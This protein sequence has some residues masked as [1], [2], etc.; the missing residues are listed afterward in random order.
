VK[1]NEEMFKTCFMAARLGQ[2]SRTLDAAASVDP[3][4]IGQTLSETKN[5]AETY[6]KHV[7]GISVESTEKS[8]KKKITPDQWEVLNV[9]ND[10][11]DLLTH[12]QRTA[13]L[14]DRLKAGSDQMITTKQAEI[15][16]SILK[17]IEPSS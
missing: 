16:S 10:M 13:F 1:L 4:L 2:Q 7:K 15:I 8:K 3:S 5:A 14:P 11:P 17:Q 9:A 12:F 6:W